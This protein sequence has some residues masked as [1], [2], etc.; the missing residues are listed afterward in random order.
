MK[1]LKFRKNLAEEIL[2]GRKTA[3][4]RLFDDKDLQIGDQ[5]E[6]LVWETKEKFATAEIIALKE[7]KLQDIK[8][9]DFIGHE[10]FASRE[11]MLENYQSFYGD[12]VN[13]ETP[14]KMLDFKII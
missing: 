5:V 12:K 7:K 3:T 14:I 6:L 13:W 11:D 10:K 8:E 1:T 2:A 9:E 4:W